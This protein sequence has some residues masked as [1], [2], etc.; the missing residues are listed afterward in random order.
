MLSEWFQC[1]LYLQGRGDLL[2]V[3]TLHPGDRS[4]GKW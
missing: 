1:E 4:D 2:S 3:L